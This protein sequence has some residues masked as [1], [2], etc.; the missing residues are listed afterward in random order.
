MVQ[1]AL[2]CL[3]PENG[4]LASSVLALEYRT[5]RNKSVCACLSNAFNVRFVYA[6]VDLQ[7]GV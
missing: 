1:K 4:N 7:P 2:F 3:C 6:T 5:T